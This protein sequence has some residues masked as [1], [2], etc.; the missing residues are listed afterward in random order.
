M[1]KK[2]LWVLMFVVIFIPKSVFADMIKINDMD[3]YS[4]NYEY[5]KMTGDTLSYVDADSDD[6]NI[7]LDKDNKKL[8]LNNFI[9]N[10]KIETDI[11]GL[12]IVLEGEN[13][14]I[15]DDNAIYASN[16]IIFSGNGSINIEGDSNGIKSEKKV[17]I[18]SGTYN[19]NGIT[20][21]WML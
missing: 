15:S 9:T 5:Y 1:C 10:K 16:N 14:V 7:R 21:E 13:E 2:M 12:N 18:N 11:D 17:T 3:I 20:Y 19:I 4:N 6:Y 8:Y